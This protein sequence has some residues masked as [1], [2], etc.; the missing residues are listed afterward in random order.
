MQTHIIDPRLAHYQIPDGDDNLG[1]GVVV[2]RAVEDKMEAA[3]GGALKVVAT[4]LAPDRVLL[5]QGPFFVLS[6]HC[7][8]RRVVA[9]LN[10]KAE[11]KS[12]MARKK[13]TKG[14]SG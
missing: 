7:Q 8:G 14:Y 3:N 1:P 4:K 12:W 5:P 11:G 10:T 2:S 13:R 6:Y 9:H